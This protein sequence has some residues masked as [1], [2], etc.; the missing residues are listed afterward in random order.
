MVNSVNQKISIIL[1]EISQYLSDADFENS[2]LLIEK[3]LMSEKIVT[4]GSG[5]VGLAMRAFAK[6][7]KHL[8]K[9][10]YFFL[11]EVLPKFSS[12]DVMI[13]ASGSGETQSMVA[14]AKKCNESGAQLI[15]IT[16]KGGQTSSIAKLADVTFVIGKPH[17]LESIQPMTTLFEQSIFLTMDAIVL[18]IMDRNQISNSEMKERHN[19]FE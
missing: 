12:N 6:R 9:D 11:D 3:V 5:R 19:V 18:T 10:A 17:K 1:N 16:G 8:G 14:L 13:L 4:V 7:L 15:L 2:E